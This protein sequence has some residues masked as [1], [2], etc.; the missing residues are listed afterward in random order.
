MAKRKSI[1]QYAEM[2]LTVRL[3]PWR[4]DLA[5]ITAA[6][7][8]DTG[9]VRLLQR[10]LWQDSPACLVLELSRVTFLGSAGLRALAGAASR[11]RAEHR[12]IGIVSTTRAVLRPLRIFGIDTHVAVYPILADAL[13][14]VP[15]SPPPTAAIPGR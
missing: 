3:V 11:A 1:H 13:R 6:G 15:L 12:R 5:I 4:H 8:I 2:I 10:A 7:E 9:S 14:E